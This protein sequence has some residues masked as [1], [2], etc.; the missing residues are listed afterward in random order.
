M[1]MI[2]LVFCSV[3]FSFQCSPK[4][5]IKDKSMSN[6]LQSYEGYFMY[7]ADAAVFKACNTETVLRVEHQYDY[8]EVEKKYL[9]LVEG[10]TWV[11]I[12]FEGEKTSQI[13]EDGRQ[14]HSIIIV[15]LKTLTKGKTCP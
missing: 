3:L 5:Q 11:F 6:S 10:G 9:A 15:E 12:H 7:M 13:N 2:F 4:T 14:I 8:L 1:K